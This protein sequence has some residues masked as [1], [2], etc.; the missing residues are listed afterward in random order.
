M[1]AT[2]FINSDFEVVI[3]PNPAQDFIAIQTQMVENDLTVE[4]I[5][6]LGQI[7]KTSKIIQG[8]T[9]AIIE[10]DTVYNGIYFVKISN[11]NQSKSY[12]VIIK[13]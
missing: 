2:S 4:L 7:V 6:E 13:K 1:D 3:A 12:K 5:N 11:G 9:L 8:S 10:T